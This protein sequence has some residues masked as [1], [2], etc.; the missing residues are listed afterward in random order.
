MSFN[1]NNIPGVRA[2]KKL[3]RSD[4]LSRFNDRTGNRILSKRVALS[5]IQGTLIWIQ[6]ETVVLLARAAAASRFLSL[7]LKRTGTMDCLAL[8][9][10][11]AGRPGL[12]SFCFAR[13]MMS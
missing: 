3:W 1:I 8:P 11:S 13:G 10:G 9:L 2:L 7:G 6:P 5:A 12:P 4:H